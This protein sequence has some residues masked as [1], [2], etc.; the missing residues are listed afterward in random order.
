[1]AGTPPTPR[2]ALVAHSDPDAEL[3]YKRLLLPCR[4]IVERAWSGPDALAKALS[5]RPDIVVAEVRLPLI[6]GYALRDLL[7]ADSDTRH[8]PVVLVSDD[9]PT[10]QGAPQQTD[11]LTRIVLRRNLEQDL[12]GAVAGL[13]AAETELP[14]ELG[15]A[16]GR[17]GENERGSNGQSQMRRGIPPPLLRCVRCDAVLA[18][19]RTYWGGVP[20][21]VER[22]DVY[23]CPG[24]CGTFEYRHRTRTIRSVRAP[25]PPSPAPVRQ[26]RLE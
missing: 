14:I 6:D 26:K 4:F 20:K 25:M 18:H 13:C 17:G 10:V 19:D 21:N 16:T 12:S 24:G 2:L 3:V 5:L 22:W 9:E 7:R 11:T 1:M 8:V 23:S 15:A